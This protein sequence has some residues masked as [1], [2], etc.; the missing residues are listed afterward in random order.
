[1]KANR[2]VIESKCPVCGSGFVFGDEVCACGVCGSYRHPACWQ[3]SGGCRHDSAAVPAAAS[4][5]ASPAAIQ[6][7]ALPP[8]EVACSGCGSMI[9]SGQG[10]AVAPDVAYGR[11]AAGIF[12]YTNRAAGPF[13]SGDTAIERLAPMLLCANCAGA[14]FTGNTWDRAREIRIEMNPN[15]AHT[16][17]AVASTR[18]V[19][20]YGIALPAKRRGIGPEQASS[21]A[22]AAAASWWKD[23]EAAS[24]P[25]AAQPAGNVCPQCGLINVGAVTRCACGYDF[26]AVTGA[27]VSVG[28]PLPP[29]SAVLAADE[30]NC[31]QCREIIK[32]AA[33]KCRFCGYV[34][35]SKLNADQIPPDVEKLVRSQANTA[36]WCGI[37]GLFICAPIFG[38]RAI[39][40]GNDAMETLNMYPAFDGPRGKA[41]TGRILG[42]RLGSCSSWV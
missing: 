10:Y 6:P 38:S 18:E 22:Y 34:L 36:L 28:P 8:A 21:E 7:A 14:I 19:L 12:F 42:W 29:G 31:P 33:L 24:Q 3:Q 15:D 26:S 1:M 23:R 37:A 41:Q 16:P 32:Q 2:K 20:D 17:E 30:R 40:N 39:S 9:A 13:E 4:V 11:T 35:D 25:P 27:P 5:A